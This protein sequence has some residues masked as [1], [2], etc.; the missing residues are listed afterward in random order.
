MSLF[1]PLRTLWPR[2]GC[3]R[4]TCTITRMLPTGRCGTA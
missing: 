3:F 2:P 1:K 4:A